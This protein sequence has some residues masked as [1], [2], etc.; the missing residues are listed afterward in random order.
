[1][2]KTLKLIIASFVG[3]AIMLIG[4]S[5]VS[6][7]QSFLNIEYSNAVEHTQRVL[8]V[9]EEFISNMKD[10]E[11]GQRGYLLTKNRS[12]L[13]PLETGISLASSH[14]DTLERLVRDNKI[15]KNSIAKI[16][17]LTFNKI[18]YIKENI[19]EVESGKNI[20]LQ[21]MDVGKKTMDT[22]RTRVKTFQSNEQDL[23]DIRI[24]SKNYGQSLMP[25]YQLLLSLASFFLLIISFY[26]VNSE[27]KR[28]YKSENA[29]ENKVEE[30][31]RSNAELEQFAYV[32]SHDLQEPLR[33]IRAFSDKLQIRQKEVLSNDGKETLDKIASSAARM[34]TL[35]DD[36]LNFSRMVNH[37][38]QIMEK[39]E[40]NKVIN[41]VLLD[42][43]DVIKKRDVAFKMINLPSI[44][45]YEFQM[46]QL[47]FNLI[48]NSLKYAREGVT[49]IININCLQVK[50]KTFKDLAPVNEETLYYKISFTD[51]GIGFE[52]K[53]AEKIFI[54]FQRLHNRNEYQGTG[55]GLAI[56][57]RILNNHSGFIFAKSEP[58][59]GTTF[60]IY[61]P[62]A[63]KT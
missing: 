10:I 2:Q 38:S 40:L 18:R 1:M 30:L 55:I 27:L 53:Y 41:E 4:L 43:S 37:K 57:K 36:L 23:L 58:Y 24:H 16:R 39:V 7:Q 32:A 12:F 5:W 35:I 19:D 17:E 21:V 44:T 52:N 20:N 6:Y 8:I 34:Q 48:S 46:K 61:F 49:P 63:S 60:D 56:C 3:F 31:N 15:Q 59:E 50:G 14:L 13:E 51:N 25:V 11:T 42:F 54:I 29:L 26:L 33:K 22:L 28:R 62:I 45:G 9:S 47:F